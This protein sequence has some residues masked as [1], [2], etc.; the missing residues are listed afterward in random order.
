[1]IRRPPRSTLFPYTTLFRSRRPAATAPVQELRTAGPV[2]RQLHARRSA[3]HSAACSGDGAGR[4]HHA[5]NRDPDI[6]A[7]GPVRPDLRGVDRAS[8]GGSTPDGPGVGVAV[9]D[10]RCA[11]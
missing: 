6:V 9:S 7:R 5:A 1:M 4:L 8:R 11:G 2:L 10:A 3:W